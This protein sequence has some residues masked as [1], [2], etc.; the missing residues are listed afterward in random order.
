[1]KKL[2]ITTDMANRETNRLGWG[3]IPEIHLTAKKKGRGSPKK[4]QTQIVVSDS[5][6]D[7]TPKKRGRKPKGGKIINN[8]SNNISIPSIPNIILHLNQIVQFFFP[9][10]S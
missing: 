7:E 1:M 3:D 9:I 10:E 2:S 5:D 4:K 6:E 8:V